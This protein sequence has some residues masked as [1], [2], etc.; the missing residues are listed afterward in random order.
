LHRHRLLESSPVGSIDPDESNE[1]LNVGVRLHRDVDRDLDHRQPI[2][3]GTDQRSNVL[4]PSGLPNLDS[5][6]SKNPG[7]W[8]LRAPVPSE[9]AGR[10]AKVGIDAPITVRVHRPITKAVDE[11]IK[12]IEGGAE[13]NF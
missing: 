13:F 7:T 9:T 3:A 12:F 10:L 1:R 5:S 2:V 11:T 4:D 8:T 6:L